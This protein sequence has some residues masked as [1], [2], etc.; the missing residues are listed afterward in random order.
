MYASC[1]EWFFKI[2]N[3]MNNDYTLMTTKYNFFVL[4]E[5]ECSFGF[6]GIS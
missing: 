6:D 5:Q 2:K 1:G 3:G 4:I